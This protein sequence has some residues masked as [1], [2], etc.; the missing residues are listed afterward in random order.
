MQYPADR[1]YAEKT[2]EAIGED[3]GELLIIDDGPHFITVTHCDLLAEKIVEWI[4]RKCS[5]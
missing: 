1:K 5:I 3:N 2:L 4:G